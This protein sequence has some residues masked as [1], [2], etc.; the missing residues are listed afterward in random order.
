MTNIQSAL[1]DIESKRAEFM[2]MVTTGDYATAE[3]VELR[4][5]DA[6][7]LYG[8]YATPL[9]ARLAHTKSLATTHYWLE[10][11]VR[12]SLANT[13]AEG[14]T[15]TTREKVP[16]RKSNTCQI[17]SGLAD[18]SGSAIQEAA[19][20]IYG[21]TLD[22]LQFQAEAEMQGLIKDIERAALLGT[23][24]TTDPRAMKG[25]KAWLTTNV[26]NVGGTT[27]GTAN[28]EN[29][30]TAIA[31]QK[32][33]HLPTAI[34]APAAVLTAMSK[35]ANNRVQFT[36]DVG[37]LEAL[38]NLRVSVGQAVGWYMTQFGPLELVLAPEVAYS[39]GTAAL[40]YLYV[41]SEPLLRF[42]DF[43]PLHASPVITTGADAQQRAIIWEGTLE[44]RCEP[45]HGVVK[46]FTV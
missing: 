4:F 23:E 34:Y 18:V 46:N 2:K 32:T 1:D 40:N 39:A 43:R 41:V 12:D 16:D 30:M 22:L 13:Q 35:W 45:A 10:A 24:S 17:V 19:N 21:S 11:G 44:V 33:G 8:S 31:D 36:A 37:N 14:D 5:A 29:L 27:L 28:I 7:T 42:A 38:R 15:P 26:E 9:T 25:L 3:A 20:G 6:V